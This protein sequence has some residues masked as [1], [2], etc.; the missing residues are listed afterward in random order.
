MRVI[1]VRIGRMMMV[2]MMMAVSVIMAVRMPVMIVAVMMMLGLLQPA[3]A[4]AK[5]VA[6]GAVRHVRAR[7]ARALAFDMVVMALL[8]R[9]HLG[10]EAQ[11]LRAVLADA[12]SSWL[13]GR[14]MNLGRALGEGVD[15]LRV[16]VEIPVPSRIGSSGLARRH[17]GR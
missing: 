5:I 3:G 8:R 14:S 7:R 15:H 2:V 6:Q 4:S 1:G 9:T 13:S 17:H 11:H 10:L 16:V 12:R